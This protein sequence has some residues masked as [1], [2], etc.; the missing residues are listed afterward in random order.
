[1][2]EQTY[3]EWRLV[4][5]SA[6]WTI[7][8]RDAGRREASIAALVEA[9]FAGVPAPESLKRDM[10][11]AL[12]FQA[13]RAAEYN[14]LSLAIARELLPGI[15]LGASLI[16]NHVATPPITVGDLEVL[17][18][19]SDGAPERAEVA[20]GPALRRATL[21]VAEAAD[22]LS[23]NTLT[24]NYYI[25]DEQGFGYY[26]LVLSAPLPPALAEPVEVLFDA[27]AQTFHYVSQEDPAALKE[28]IG[29]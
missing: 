6:W 22:D 2:G 5:P 1:M 4:L 10:R 20:A 27:V 23:V 15:P 14:G 9:Q 17:L 28:A 12:E 29:E 21:G 13:V 25:P 19:W 11:S 3:D 16:V 24:V 18:D 7:P 26:G 8:L